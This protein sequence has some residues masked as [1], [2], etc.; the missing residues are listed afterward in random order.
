MHYLDFIT[1]APCPRF[2]LVIWVRP[3]WGP[4]AGFS[5]AA[6]CHGPQGCCGTVHRPREPH[7]VLPA[8]RYS[9]CCELPWRQGDQ[10]GSG[11]SSAC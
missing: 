5:M 7:G 8:S 11:E 4:G 3:Q 10:T 1:H 6:I 9:G 2:L